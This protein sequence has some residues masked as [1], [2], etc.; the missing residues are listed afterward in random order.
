MGI[1][2]LTPDSFSDGGRFQQRDAALAMAERM[3][4]DGADLLDLGAESSRPGATPVPL[5]QEL[6]R[7]MPV[8][9]ALRDAPVPLSVDTYKPE[10]MRAA[11]SAGASV[12]NDIFALR[13][14]GA[15]DAVAR[16]NCG[17]VLMHMQG[18]PQSMQ[19]QPE[20]DDVVADVSEF[21]SQRIA[22]AQAAGIDT[23]RIAVDPGFG[24]GKRAIDNETLLEKLE[25]F[26]RL[27]AAGV[28]VGLSRKSMLAGATRRPPAA[29]VGASI[30]A[31]LVAFQHGARII[32]CHDVAA[33]CDALKLWRQFAELRNKSV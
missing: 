24:F 4:E 21:L 26:S 25:A 18:E 3:I 28:L 13:K 20:Y 16:V 6:E 17:L 33:T 7:L 23:L 9:E 27:P 19:E 31:A 32:R 10:V 30:A 2:N 29:R 15:I 1:L 11:L 5:D 14:P 22:D 12:V 8:L